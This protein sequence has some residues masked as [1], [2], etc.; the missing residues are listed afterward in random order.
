[1]SKLAYVN[2]RVASKQLG[3]IQNWY[4]DCGMVTTKFVQNELVELAW[5]KSTKSCGNIYQTSFTIL[6]KHFF[7]QNINLIFFKV[8]VISALTRFQNLPNHVA[9]YTGRLVHFQSIQK[10]LSWQCL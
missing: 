7:I 2:L 1:M 5:E 3:A 9:T 4:N 8:F 10:M 6:Q